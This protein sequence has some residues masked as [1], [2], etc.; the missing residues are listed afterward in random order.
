MKKISVK[1]FDG[2]V[3]ET[4][5]NDYFWNIEE[6][7]NDTRFDFIALGNMYIKKN[8]ISLIQI[9]DVEEEKDEIENKES[10]K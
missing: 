4:T 10:E 7:L 6:K 5:N 8:D 2:S 1:L 9:I 3:F